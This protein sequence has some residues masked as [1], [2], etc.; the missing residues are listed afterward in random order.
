MPMDSDLLVLPVY[1]GTIFLFIRF[2]LVSLVSIN[3]IFLIVSLAQTQSTDI[4]KYANQ[5][6]SQMN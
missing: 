6:I 4:A 3:A 2:I 1:L 5:A